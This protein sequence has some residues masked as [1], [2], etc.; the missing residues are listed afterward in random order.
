MLNKFGG[1]N[2][3]RIVIIISFFW[4][5]TNISFSRDIIVERVN[6]GQNGYNVVKEHHDDG[7]FLRGKKSILQCFDPGN[8]QCQW[9]IDPRTLP[10]I[11]NTGVEY[12]DLQ[13]YAEDKIKNGVPS[14]TFADPKAYNGVLYN[15]SVTWTS[16]GTLEN[17]E[18]IITIE[19]AED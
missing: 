6:G 1:G 14:G 5:L 9:N 18:I 15:R 4:F 7:G 17:S 10:E 2:M 8:I 19:P 12:K 11:V 16:N 13:D 3:K